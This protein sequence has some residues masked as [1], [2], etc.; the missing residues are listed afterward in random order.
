MTA[1]AD[2]ARTGSA[3]AFAATLLVVFGAE[4]VVMFALLL[5]M[6]RASALVTTVVDASVLAVLLVPA[7]W[8]VVARS[9]HGEGATERLVAEHVMAHAGDAIVTMDERGVILSANRVAAEIFARPVRALVGADVGILMH[10]ADRSGHPSHLVRYLRTGEKHIIDRRREA[11]AMRADG[12]AFPVELSISELRL[13]E[14]RLFA[15]IIRDVSERHEAE[16]A[17]RASEERYRLLFDGNP[18]PLLLLDPTTLHFLAVNDAAVSQY[19]YARD[20]FL[21]LTVAD[22]RTPEEVPQ[23]LEHMASPAADGVRR[24][25][26]RHRRKD[27]SEFVADIVSHTLDV[28]GRPARLVIAA[29][30]SERAALEQQLRQA[31][32]MEAVGQLAGGMAHDFNNLLSTV[33]TTAELIGGELPAGSPL[34]DDLEIIRAAASRGA[35]LTANARMCSPCRFIL[36]PGCIFAAASGSCAFGAGSWFSLIRVSS[37]QPSLPL[38]IAVKDQLHARRY[39]QLFKDAENIVLDRVRA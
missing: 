34:A 13:G 7:F 2:T 39:S 37:E 32:K 15:A 14:R 29:D 31:Q 16:R 25:R 20:E 23:L 11:T 36:V 9:R 1:R 28:G 4:F 26:V 18:T 6:P 38:L 3:R 19:G 21:Q 10:P 12:S 5:L 17:L 24:G 30:V 33:L 35:A 22:L 27:G 8:L